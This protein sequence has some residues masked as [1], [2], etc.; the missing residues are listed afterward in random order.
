VV[1]GVEYLPLSLN[2][3]GSASDPDGYT[4]FNINNT[5]NWSGVFN[6]SSDFKAVTGSPKAS[7]NF[8]IGNFGVTREQ[9]L[10]AGSGTNSLPLSSCWSVRLHADGQWTTQPLISNEQFANGGNSGVRGYRDGQIYSDTGW[11]TQLEFRSPQWD[12]GLVDGTAHMYGRLFAFM[13]YGQ[14]YLLDPGPGADKSRDLWGTG[15][16]FM[17]NIGPHVDARVTLGF[18]LLDQPGAHRGTIRV[19]FAV[20]GQF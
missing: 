15:F 17:S 1:N 3:E 20:G 2:W 19:T 16:G 5:F 9:K 10:F 8:Y 11:R 12:L 4:S 7:G 6:N 18:P 14:S 13:D